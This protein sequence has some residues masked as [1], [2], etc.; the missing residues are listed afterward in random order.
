MARKS[1]SK[2]PKR[3]S[4]KKKRAPSQYNIFMK[5][6]IK[7]LQKTHPKLAHTERFRMAAANW[8]K[9]H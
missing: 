7:K 6:E 2:S 9:K 1:A 3:S 4:P 8:S 5:A